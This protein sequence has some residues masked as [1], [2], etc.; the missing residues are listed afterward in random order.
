MKHIISSI[1]VLS[2]T[3][4]AE[5]AKSSRKKIPSIV[6]SGVIEAPGSG[7]T[8]AND[9]RPV[10]NRQ[11]V[12]P[13]PPRATPSAGSTG[14]VEDFGATGVTGGTDLID[15]AE[16][17]MGNSWAC[18]NATKEEFDA[19]DGA[20][21]WDITNREHITDFDNWSEELVFMEAAQRTHQMTQCQV[22]LHDKYE[23]D[24]L[25]S[26]TMK[27]NA[28]IQFQDI[29][30]QLGLILQERDRVS[31]Q[32]SSARNSS[33]YYE[34]R[35][36][37]TLNQTYGYEREVEGRLRDVNERLNSLMS[38]VPMGNRVQM[39]ERLVSLARRPNLSEQQFYAE[40]ESVMRQLGSEA[41][42]SQ[43]FF[44]G[45]LRAVPSGQAYLIN[46]DL[47]KSLV[48]SGQ[49][50]NVI[51][52]LGLEER[53]AQGFSCRVRARYQSGPTNLMVA[54]IPLYF[55]GVYG[56]GRLAVRAGV[57]G[58]RATSAAART[59]AE[60]TAWSARAAMLG[61]EGYT[62]ARLGD[63]VRETCFPPEY[64]TA[65]QNDA[66]CT[67]ESEVNG[68]YQ[69]ASISQCLT[70]A[71]IAIAP[72]AFVGAVRV[73][74]RGPTRPVPENIVTARVADE[75]PTTAPISRIVDEAPAPSTVVEEIIVTAP[76]R[77]NP[78]ITPERAPGAEAWTTVNDVTRVNGLAAADKTFLRNY[79]RGL[80]RDVQTKLRNHFRGQSPERTLK[81]LQDMRDLS[82]INSCR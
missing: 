12:A 24:S 45:I 44:N 4:P 6:W 79:M 69:N 10:R 22:K 38:R 77:R 7:R 58:V 81:D 30:Q 31:D 41:R 57:A 54:E 46:E 29:R 8:P 51:A 55:L 75:V 52:S 59:S 74:R 50:E 37:G 42:S 76:R 78:N 34:D 66:G 56:L 82:R 26:T 73:W 28:Y 62:W 71:A 25:T 11:P 67:A 39:R 1:L 60:I 43:N 3:L 33:N 15:R 16:G 23:S 64:L 9:R 68:V 17:F 49:I 36:S 47:K 35:M 21:G 63:S 61:I 70:T 53:L 20:C 27:Q 65:V 2:I 14:L 19:I 72:V 18:N 13:R 48:K 80:P 5:A 32:L 40:Y